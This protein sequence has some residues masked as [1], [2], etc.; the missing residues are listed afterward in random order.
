M[1]P[2]TVGIFGLGYVGMATLA[3]LCPKHKSIG[4]EVDEE[5]I[6][7]LH[8]KGS[9]INDSFIED[10]SKKHKINYECYKK[11]DDYQE[12]LDW[13]IICLPT[14]YNIVDESL[15]TRLIEKVSSNILE[16]YPNI[17]I[18]IKSTL[19]YG[20]TEKLI[21]KL[22]YKHIYFV[23]EFLTEDKP[24]QDSLSP[25]RL[26]IGGADQNCTDYEAV[27]KSCI[28]KSKLKVINCLPSE[29]ETTK[30]F[31]NTYLA[32]RVAFF[33]ELDS[34]AMLENLNTFKV[35]ESVCSDPRIGDHYN[36]PSFGYGGYC[37]PKDTR[38]LN[39]SFTYPQN[40]LLGSI[41]VSNKTRKDLII[42]YAL[43]KS[44]SNVGIL[45]ISMKSDS[46][47]SREAAIE[48]IAQELIKKRNVLVY[49][50]NL[51]DLPD[52]LIGCNLIKSKEEFY[53]KSDIIL[54]NRNE[55]HLISEK[56]FSRDIYNRD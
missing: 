3:L 28:A 55:N 2:E 9:T 27:I 15:D 18:F 38:Q 16:R 36:N 5:K 6:S 53:E 44:R 17:A 56:V 51:S 50:T 13:A 4:F 14:N 10:Y 52:A 33:N 40:V 43:S 24:L 46:N 31:A 39:K 7:R 19:P 32:M 29:A 30:L 8:C 49:D 35:L 20:F 47:N 54:S 11:L 48:Y 1:K 26:V 23:P 42:E 22:D 12:K 37:L 45:G 25:T 21:E 34:F 41:E